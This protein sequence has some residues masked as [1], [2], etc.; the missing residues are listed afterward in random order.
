M[1]CVGK[2]LTLLLQKLVHIDTALLEAA[3]SHVC[4]CV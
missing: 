1:R 4:V 2:L 3:S